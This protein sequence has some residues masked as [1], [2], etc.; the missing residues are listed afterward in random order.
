MFASPK[1]A[2]L[3]LPPPVCQS[4]CL[5]I[6]GNGKKEGKEGKKM[7]GR[8]RKYRIPEHSYCKIH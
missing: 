1:R 7:E 3:S 2:P 5:R 6:S 4:P 8:K